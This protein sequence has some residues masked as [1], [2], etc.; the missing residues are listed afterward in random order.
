MRKQVDRLLL[1]AKLF[2]LLILDNNL[3]IL[4]LRYDY[5]IA[6]VLWPLTQYLYC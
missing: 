6:K 3:S 1:A 2:H 4:S 5:L